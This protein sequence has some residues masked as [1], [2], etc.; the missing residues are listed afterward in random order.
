MVLQKTVKLLAYAT[1]VTL[2]VESISIAVK[3]SF[4]AACCHR[5]TFVV[6]ASQLAVWTLQTVGIEL[7]AE[8]WQ[9][10]V[11]VIKILFFYG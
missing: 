5:A 8:E 11:D 7:L 4:A 1:A 2:V 3:E 9:Q 6:L 10:A